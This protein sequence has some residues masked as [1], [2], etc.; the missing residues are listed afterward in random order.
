MGV[1]GDEASLSKKVEMLWG[2]PLSLNLLGEIGLSALQDEND[3]ELVADDIWAADDVTGSRMSALVAHYEAFLDPRKRGILYVLSLF[4]DLIR[5]D[6]LE[7]LCLELADTPILEDLAGVSR[8]VLKILIDDMRDQSPLASSRVQGVEYVSLHPLVRRAVRQ[9]LQ[10][11]YPE[12]YQAVQRSIYYKLRDKLPDK[13]SSM[14]DVADV[15]RAIRHGCEGGLYAEVFD[16]LIWDKLQRGYAAY[17][18]H[19]FGAGGLDIAAMNRYF[20]NG[21]FAPEN[22]EKS[23]DSKLLQGRIFIWSGFALRTLARFDESIPLLE[24]A[25]DMLVEVEPQGAWAASGYLSRCFVQIGRL[26]EGADEAKRCVDVIRQL[27]MPPEYLRIG[28]GVYAIAL[29]YQGRFDECSS[30]YDE[31]YSMTAVNPN[32]FALFAMQECQYRECLM[33]RFGVSAVEEHVASRGDIIA[34]SPVIQEMYSLYA[35]PK[36]ALLEGDFSS[37]RVAAVVAGAKR[38]RQGSTGWVA[39]YRVKGLLATV[40]Y[41]RHVGLMAEAKEVLEV[42]GEICRRHRLYVLEVDWLI[43]SIQILIAEGEQLRAEEEIKKVSRQLDQYG[44]GLRLEQ[45]EMLKERLLNLEPAGNQIG[46][47]V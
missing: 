31:A 35:S 9:R 42:A 6:L 8:T 37:A 10:Q 24:R 28:L 26:Q 16:Q 3:P 23:I 22:L 32:M 15:N 11:N 19:R 46:V 45:V 1:D 5:Q 38:L 36:E 21:W 30:A 34:H 20:S 2:H 41:F 14:E 33:E 12:Q 27:N 25:R 47:A 44:Y 39:D 29:F 17:A 40:A 7:Q 13:V 4:D 18:L 43:E